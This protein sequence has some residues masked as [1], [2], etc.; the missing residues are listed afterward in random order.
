MDVNDKS[1]CHNGFQNIIVKRQDIPLFFEKGFP[2]ASLGEPTD[3]DFQKWPI[4][5]LISD[6]PSDSQAL[7]D[8]DPIPN[9]LRGNST[10]QTISLSLVQLFKLRIRWTSRPWFMQSGAHQTY[11]LPNLRCLKQ[12][13]R[14]F[15]HSWARDGQ[16]N[17]ERYNSPGQ[18]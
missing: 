13:L 6:D 16:E 15:V 2:N 1:K 7:D 11:R 3:K 17:G 9:N 12:K 4:L 14:G 18:N 5:G 8:Q 10:C